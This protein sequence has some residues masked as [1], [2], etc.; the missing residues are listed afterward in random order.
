MMSVIYL[1]EL[2]IRR[3]DV[4]Y[5]SYLDSGIKFGTIL[6]SLLLPAYDTIVDTLQSRQWLAWRVKGERFPCD[7]IRSFFRHD[8]QRARQSGPADQPGIRREWE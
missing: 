8:P 7:H 3:L 6:L 1:Y 2:R 4:I 5:S